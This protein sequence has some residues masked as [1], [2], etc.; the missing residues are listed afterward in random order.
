MTVY[1]PESRVT[2][3]LL[4]PEIL[5]SGPKYGDEA[6]PHNDKLGLAALP[7]V[8]WNP[9]EEIHVRFLPNLKDSRLSEDR[10]RAAIRK[11]KDFAKEWVDAA[12]IYFSFDGANDAPVRV[13]LFDGA[14]G[15]SWLGTSCRNEAANKPTMQLGVSTDETF[16]FTVLHEFGHVLGL[17]H[18]HSSPRAGIKWK[19]DEVLTHFRSSY[20]WDDSVVEKEVFQVYP[21]DEVYA[22][23]AFDRE[24]VMIYPISSNLTEDGMSAPQNSKLS[25]RDRAG[26]ITIYPRNAIEESKGVYYS[27]NF[28]P[29]SRFDPI[30]RAVIKLEPTR[31]MPSAIAVG[32]AQADLARG[33][34]LRLKARAHSL[35]EGQFIAATE[36]W[37]AGTSRLASAGVMWLTLGTPGTAGFQTGEVD[38][39]RKYPPRSSLPASAHIQVKFE[40]SFSAAPEVVLWIKGFHIGQSKGGSEDW[41]LRISAESITTHG[42]Y[43]AMSSEPGS[44]VYRAIVTWVAFRKDKSGV[45]HGIE[46]G[47]KADMQVWDGLNDNR[48][49]FTRVIDLREQ[50]KNQQCTAK[51]FR[52]YL[53]IT[54]FHFKGEQ[55]LRFHAET[56]MLEDDPEIMANEFRVFVGTWNKSELLEASASWLAIYE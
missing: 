55:N 3:A 16:K 40:T 39:S 29:Y 47:T 32:I 33:E 26:I 48:R 10:Y 8:F 23:G 53:G 14:G 28:K 50:K 41:S 45:Y 24:S 1:G 25:S 11:V 38:S 5:T 9:G 44:K 2:C 6:D 19:R 13:R 30:N 31:P 54:S 34:N 15:V 46:T 22:P 49:G 37:G 52:V 42:F 12:N 27:W 18:E 17:V 7:T 56:E 51:V 36:T 4:R 43:V 21:Y 20:G 35:E